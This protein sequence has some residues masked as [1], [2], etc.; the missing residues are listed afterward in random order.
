MPSS[1]RSIALP[2]ADRFASVSA[3]LPGSD[4]PWLRDIRTEALAR[5]RRQELPS[6]RV[7]RWKYTNLHP[8]AAREFATAVP[9]PAIDKAPTA[10][11]AI[12]YA[13]ARLVF[14]NGVLQSLGHRPP[15]QGRALAEHAGSRSRRCRLAAP[16][17]RRGKDR[18]STRGVE[19]RVH[20]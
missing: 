5:F 18:R 8:V 1:N 7:E 6:T 11:P 12:A 19:S 13:L 20:V 9:T 10:A 2:Y 17:T 4:L 15:A 3:S 14:V 16:L